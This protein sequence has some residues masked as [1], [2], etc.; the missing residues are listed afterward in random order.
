RL[1]R[2]FGWDTNGDHRGSVGSDSAG[3]LEAL[4]RKSV[5]NGWWRRAKAPLGWGIVSRSNHEHAQQ[6][7]QDHNPNDR[8]ERQLE[9]QFVGPLMLAVVHRRMAFGWIDMHSTSSCA[10]NALVL[11]GYSI[12]PARRCIQGVRA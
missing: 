8:A 11:L 2:A 4:A 9:K 6:R 3:A 12:K 1:V 10:F 7:Q 5:S